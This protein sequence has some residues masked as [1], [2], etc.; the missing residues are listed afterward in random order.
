[1]ATNVFVGVKNTQGVVDQPATI[2]A[3]TQNTDVELNI[4]SANV[5]DKETVLL[6]L[7]KIALAIVNGTWPL[8]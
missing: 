7:E 5:P 2:A 3:A 1:M 4:L 6:A 8:I